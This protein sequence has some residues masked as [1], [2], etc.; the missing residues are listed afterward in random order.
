M[1]TLHHHRV[2][3]WVFLLILTTIGG[4]SDGDPHM[5]VP[6]ETDGGVLQPDAGRKQFGPLAVDTEA[7]EQ[8]LDLFGKVGHRIWIEVSEE[9]RQ[10]MNQRSGGGFPGPVLQ[11]AGH[12]PLAPAYELAWDGPVDPG[13]GGDIYT[14]G[15]TEEAPT[16]ADHLVIQDAA[17]ESVADYGQMKVR[18]IGESTYRQWTP[19]T[20][21][22]VRIDSNEYDKDLFIG[23]FEHIRLNNGLVGTIF[24]EHIAHRVF[25]GLGYPALR[26]TFAFLGSN[27]WGD[28]TWIPMTL[29][30]VYKRRFCR[31]N[32]DLL[33]GT[34]TNMWEYPGDAGVGG[35]PP[36]ACQV[37][38][39]D[40]QRMN[41]LEQALL[42][43]PLGP[44]FREALSDIID[45]PMFHRFHC[46]SWI[47]ATGDD[48]LR[49]LN[50]NLIIQ[51]DGDGKLIFAPYSV[52]ISAGQEW[53]PNPPLLGNSSL[54]RGCQSDPDCWAGTVA[55]CETL[56]AEFDALDPE[57]IVDETR[58][59]LTAH[60]MMRPGDEERAAAIREWFVERQTA[61]RPELE[62]YRYLPDP[63]GVCPNDLVAC[64]DGGC[65]TPADCETRRCTPPSV[66]CEATQQC[67]QE[68]WQ[69]CVECSGEVP[70]YC[71]VSAMSCVPDL[72]AC[73][74]ECQEAMGPGYVYC[75]ATSWCEMQIFCGSVEPLPES[76]DAGGAPLPDE[77]D[78]GAIGLW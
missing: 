76:P 40:D 78:G 24:R 37:G 72:E 22:N 73:S 66:W 41:D 1:L 3:S 31:D 12:R 34:C 2:P 75:P 29:V 63:F 71:P 48:A 49:A 45:W 38:E 5:R 70:F 61:L 17:T 54:A 51:R 46:I 47:L 50:N 57:K 69:S 30:E 27:V 28:A 9:Q 25:R 62:R 6:S 43:A 65:G 39:C 18:L 59:A 7:S 64:N 11:Q 23:G 33:G 14:P 44:G 10:R 21:P 26:S 20:I 77:P 4:C 53:Q 32:A 58:D 16:F 67:I 15:D 55:A 8:A 13:W 52:D 68:E 35:L 19:S 74:I 36:K 60:G 42:E 56:V